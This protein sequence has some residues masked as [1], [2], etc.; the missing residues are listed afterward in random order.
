MSEYAFQGGNEQAEKFDARATKME[1]LRMQPVDEIV[2][3]RG[4]LIHRHAEDEVEIHL[5]NT[6]LEEKGIL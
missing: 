3:L 6:I 4:A 1:V 2:R 5:L